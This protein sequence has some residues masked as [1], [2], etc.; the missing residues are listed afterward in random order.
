MED[1][2]TIS[3]K[4]IVVETT[5][6]A[7]PKQVFD[8]WTTNAGIR[9]FFAKDCQVELKPGGKFEMYFIAD[10]EPG[11]KGSEGCKVLSYLP[12]R[13][14][15]FNWNAPP[16]LMEVRNHPHKTCVVILF[17]DL[18]DGSTRVEL[19]HLGWLEGGQWDEVFEYFEKAW[20]TVLGWLQESFERK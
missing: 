11:L 19:T 7:T 6:L 4:Q 12:D 16:H 17:D 20:V 2:I 1:E 8:R 15:T 10:A 3:D 9:Q 14:F 5:V 13:M 18:G